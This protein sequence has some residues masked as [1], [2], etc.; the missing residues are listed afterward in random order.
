MIDRQIKI[1]VKKA[2][3]RQAAVALIGP[4]QVGKT[5]LALDLA[6]QQDSVYLDLETSVD[7]AKLQNPVLFLSQ[8]ENKLVILDEI[9]RMP[10]IFQELRGL[11]DQGRRKGLKAGRFLILGSASI[12]LLRQSGETLAGRI[13][14]INMEPINITETDG[15][16]IT[17]WVRGGFPES[18]LANDDEDSF[19]Y[20][21]NF[22]RTYLERD[23]P[24]FGPRIAAETL[25]RLW[26]MLAHSQGQTLNAS[27][28][29][30]SLAISATTVNNYIDLLADLLLIRRLQPYYFNT[31]KRLVKAPK[32]Y[33]RDSGLMHALIGLKDY[34]TLAG[35]PASG[36]SWEAFVIENLLSV[37]PD[38]TKAC[39]YRTSAGAEVDLILE[40]QAGKKWT[41]EIKSGLTP[42]LGKGAHHA[43]E[44]I[45]AEK[46]FVV[47]AGDDRYPIADGVEVIGLSELASILKDI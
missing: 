27:K 10:E 4:R 29:A 47:Y 38:Y 24:Q 37:V 19:V 21:L 30:S 45:Q 18:L 42:K 7:R 11:I 9:H 33:V 3:S 31:K 13:E 35:H 44:E 16:P 2:L 26:I 41:V 8:N 25:E 23:I 40:F 14:Y 6:E 22:I 5:T 15:D 43:L 28:L 1:K 36:A 12:E 20:R 17:L 34:N 46:S 39:Y 32:V